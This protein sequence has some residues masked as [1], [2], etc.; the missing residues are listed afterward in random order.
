MLH[1]AD[2]SATSCGM[3]TTVPMD[4]VLSTV[5]K[6]MVNVSKNWGNVCVL[7]DSQEKIVVRRSAPIT[8]MAMVPVTY[9]QGSVCV[10]HRGGGMHVEIRPAQIIVMAT[11]N[12]SKESASATMAT[13]VQTAG[14]NPALRP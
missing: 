3:A 11:G 2:A 7:L 8:A 14:T 10:N 13:R 1:V 5:S 9:L 4:N 12:V 6:H